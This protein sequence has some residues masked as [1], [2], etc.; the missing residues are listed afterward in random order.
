MKTF[1]KLS[2]GMSVVNLAKRGVV[3][4]P[5]L[6]A[7]TTPGSFRLTAPVTRALGIASGDYVM[8]V[9]NTAA[10]DMAIAQKD[11]ELVAWCQ[12]NNIDITSPAGIDAIHEA[13]DMWAVAKGI[14]EFDAKGNP[15]KVSERWTKDAKMAYVTNDFDNIFESAKAN[16]EADFV[17]ALTAEGMTKE[18]QIE[19]IAN[20]L[21]PEVVDKYRGAK[22]AN[23]SKFVGIGNVVTFADAS[24]WT[25]LKANMGE[26]MKS[27]S[28]IFSVDI[29]EL[30]D[31]VINDG[32]KD[33]TIKA[34]VLKEY[35]DV[36]STRKKDNEEGENEETS[37]E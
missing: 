6:I 9:G 5:E 35:R 37:A 13:F 7:N 34:A 18:A 21:Q 10:I 11:E 12:E 1:G 33:V 23:P 19:M 8:F 29:T 31:V 27:H 36:E 17:A 26:T 32:C 24:V 4:E 16:G 3:A 30:M 20:S 14:Q 15:I 22:C 25:A 28:R 2:F